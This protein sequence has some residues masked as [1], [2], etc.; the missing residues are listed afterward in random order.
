MQYIIKKN[1]IFHENYQ[2]IFEKTRGKYLLK[3]LL[4]KIL[5]Y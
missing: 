2:K 3:N 4:I 5:K 1:K